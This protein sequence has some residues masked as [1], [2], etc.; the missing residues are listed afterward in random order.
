MNEEYNQLSLETDEIEKQIENEEKSSPYNNEDRKLIT[1]P[2]DMSVSTV[3]EQIKSGDIQLGPEYQ[4]MYRWQNDKAS[5]FIE[6]L[7]LNI[8]I[9]TVF[10]AEEED[11]TYSVIDGSKT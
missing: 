2:Y 1:Q 10:L 8:P 9:P 3:V 11:V 4:R 5:K 6:S 7:L